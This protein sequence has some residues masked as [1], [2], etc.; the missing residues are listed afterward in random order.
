LPHRYG[1]G[2]PFRVRSSFRRSSVD[3]LSLAKVSDGWSPSDAVVYRR[4]GTASP[5]AD[6]YSPVGRIRVE[7]R[8]AGGG[9]AWAASSV[10][11]ARRRFH[12]TDANGT[13]S[14]P[15][16]PQPYPAAVDCRWTVAVA[17]R[18]TVRLLFAYFDTEA[19]LD[20]LTVRKTTLNERRC[21]I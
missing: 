8:A 21:F 18:R 19:N 11:V 14:T 4:N 13:L 16:Y 1:D 10:A 3:E 12:L 6:W 5:Q 2:P 15:N 9:R 7:T 20:L 17:A